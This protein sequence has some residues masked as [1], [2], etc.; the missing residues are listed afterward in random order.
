[1][2]RD[3]RSDGRRAARG[4][5]EG[6]IDEGRPGAHCPVHGRNSLRCRTEND[7]RS[8][9]A[10]RREHGLCERGAGCPAH[11]CTHRLTLDGCGRAVECAAPPGDSRHATYPWPARASV[12]LPS[13][14]VASTI[15][16]M[17][18]RADSVE[19]DLVFLGLLAMKD[20]LRSEAMEAVRLC[21]EAGITTV[22][23]TGD[24][25]ETAVAIATRARPL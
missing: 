2:A 15:L 18:L 6:R 9:V 3:R 5:G 12:C 20:P 22:M 7:D 24:H 25:K 1:M 23:I 14:I 19:R 10:R 21:R 13:R 17:E 16:R 11:R 8:S 4:C